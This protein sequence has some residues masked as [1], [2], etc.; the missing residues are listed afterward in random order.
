MKMEAGGIIGMVA[1]RS[2]SMFMPYYFKDDETLLGMTAFA[3]NFYMGDRAAEYGGRSLGLGVFFASNLDH[4]HDAGSVALMRSLK[5]HL[6][7][8]D[9]INPGHLVCGNTKF[10]ISLNKNI[11]GV[12]SKLMCGVKKIMP[13]NKTFE[14]NLKRFHYDD[15]EHEKELSR[16]VEYGKGTE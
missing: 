15:M 4:V 6:D 5:T 13:A 3:Y 2:T 9:V 16:D 14:R 11:M 12:A 7:P 8:H 1:D 10:G